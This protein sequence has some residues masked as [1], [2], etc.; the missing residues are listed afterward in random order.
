MSVPATTDSDVEA[1]D[2]FLRGDDTAL[3]DLF[4]R[5]NQKLYTYC[6]KIV[7]DPVQAED[8]TQEIWERVVKLRLNP[9]Q[10]HNPI[11]FFMRIA[12]NL[13]INHVK[14]RRPI[15]SLGSLSEAAHPTAPITERTELEETVQMALGD[16]S[17][18]YREVLVLNIYCGYPFEE[19]AAMLGKSPDAIW[20]RASRARAR[21]RSAVTA[22]IGPDHEELRRYLTLDERKR[23]EERS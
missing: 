15:S 22:R 3:A 18:D 7:G 10:I 2:R 20:M 17:F 9:Q 21:L 4:D 19:I 12:R 11:A 23:S 6:L 14:S 16:L 13:C 1:L 8:M 5:H